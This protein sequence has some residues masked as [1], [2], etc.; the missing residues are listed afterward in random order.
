MYKHIL[1][2]TD[3][4]AP[5]EKAATHALALASHLKTKVTAVMITPPKILA[6]A[7]GQELQ[8]AAT[9]RAG[10]VLS[11]LRDAAAKANVP[12]VAL[13]VPDQFP[14][15]GILEMAKAGGCD[16]IVMGAHGG[17]GLT[18]RLIGSQAIKV[19]MQSSV[20][21]LIYR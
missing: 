5:A 7:L 10:Q 9:A 18:D 20:P 4:S 3:G 21:V 1:I 12:C 16:L 6:T 13:H 19:L 11:G 14:A 2:A 8:T 15:E 17:H